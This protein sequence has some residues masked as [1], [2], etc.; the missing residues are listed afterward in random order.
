MSA[1]QHRLGRVRLSIAVPTAD[2]DRISD[3]CARLFRQEMRSVI[4]STL[5]AAE[6]ACGALRV[7]DALVIDVGALPAHGFEQ[8]L[9]QRLAEQLMRELQRRHPALTG[10]GQDG[11]ADGP[12]SL[13]EEAPGPAGSADGAGGFDGEAR[14]DVARAVA[15]P[16]LELPGLARRCLHA[17]EL[18]RLCTELTA[19]EMRQLATLLAPAAALAPQAAPSLPVRALHYFIAHP[20]QPMPTVSP[21]DAALV[22]WLADET[23]E[24]DI[25]LLQEMFGHP[26]AATGTPAAW[27]AVLWQLPIVR[28]ILARSLP[29]SIVLQADP[30]AQAGTL[31]RPLVLA[32]SSAARDAASGTRSLLAADDGGLAPA[33]P[34]R[35]IHGPGVRDTTVGVDSAGLLAWRRSPDPAGSTRHGDAAAAVARM[36][37]DLGPAHAAASRPHRSLSGL[38][39]RAHEGP[40]QHAIPVPNAG[41]SLLWPFLPPL[42]RS[43]GLLGELR[44]LN[45]QAQ[46]D[47]AC[48]LDVIVW[49]EPP[50]DDA[51][52][53]LNRLLCNLPLEVPLQPSPEVG[54]VREVLDGFVGCLPTRVPGWTRLAAADIRALFLQRPG[55]V[56]PDGGDG[57]TVYVEPQ[58]YDA[59]LDHV[60]W[61]IDMVLLPWCA[62]PWTVRRELLPE[63][64]PVTT[65]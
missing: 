3:A 40:G 15:H 18:R 32:E 51:R 48:W 21:T 55:W 34:R 20:A 36:R 5:D 6:Q 62:R 26:P 4:A 22:P 33:T 35:A 56:V 57:C 47:A 42:W 7:D 64:L 60:P 9:A 53:V 23:D 63:V 39:P 49:G 28:S 37:T 14:S 19:P 50:K 29:P 43:L 44:F 8:L 13:A 31:A 58:P 30:W 41:V 65:N 17:A 38:R 25:R 24:S 11:G 46:H 52:T 16:S 1:A 2:A 54:A 12:D 61:P 59:L 10:A 45:E 27:L